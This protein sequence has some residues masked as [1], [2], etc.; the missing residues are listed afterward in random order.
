MPLLWC[1][2]NT[3]RNVPISLLLGTQMESSPK[4][5]VGESHK[6]SVIPYCTSLRQAAPT[7]PAAKEVGMLDT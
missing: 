5:F 3:S 2:Y 1:G 7:L 4:E 6:G